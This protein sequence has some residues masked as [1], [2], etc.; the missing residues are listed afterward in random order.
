MSAAVPDIEA[1]FRARMQV[2]RV[3]FALMDAVAEDDDAVA[4][5]RAIQ[6]KFPD[7]TIAD[8]ISAWDILEIAAV[9]AVLQ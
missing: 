6:G 5:L 3:A 7:T 4:V 2:Y 9:P 8:L 1:V